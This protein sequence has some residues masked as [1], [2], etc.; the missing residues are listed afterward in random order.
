MRAL[1]LL[2]LFLA[3]AADASV[4]CTTTDL[5]GMA[6][7][8]NVQ[9]GPYELECT[10]VHVPSATAFVVRDPSGTLTLTLG[11]GQVLP[12]AGD[13]IRVRGNAGTTDRGDVRAYAD[14]IVRLGRTAVPEPP[15]A[16][17]GK[18]LDGRFD[19]RVVR[20]QGL[21]IDIIQDEI[22]S[23]FYYLL[24]YADG[25]KL[26]LSVSA[27]G[28]T[29]EDFSRYAYA[30]VEAV[31][32]CSSNLG[33]PRRYLGP[34]LTVRPDALRIL[35]PARADPFDALADD[36]RR[37]RLDGTVAAV[38]HGDRF[39][40][41]TDDGQSALVIVANGRAL[42]AVGRHV[43][44][45][46]VVRT[47][48]FTLCLTSAIWRD[49]PGD[50]PPEDPPKAV[51]A[52]ELL[53]AV[54]SQMKFNA[55]LH[56]R[57]I[58]FEGRV[59]RL[60]V[61]DVEDPSVF[62]ECGPLVIPVNASACPSALEGLDVGCR[63]RATGMAIIE[64][65]E[66]RSDFHFPHATGMSV[67][68]RRP[69]DLELVAR[70]PWWTAGRL[71]AVIGS[72]VLLLIGI[73]IWNRILNR[74]VERRGR[75]LM[76][77]EIAHAEADLK[78]E[79]RTR[80]A[81]ELHDTLAQNLTGVSLQID[82]AEMASAKDPPSARPYLARARMKMQNCRE[83]L[84]DCL[85]DLRSRAIDEKELA[86]AIRRTLAPHLG[87]ATAEIACDV[88]CSDLSDNA[89]H[90][91]LCIVRELVVN[92]IRHGGATAVSVSCALRGGRLSLAVRDDGRGFDPASR[93]GPS[94]GHFGLQGVGER[95]RRLGGTWR[96]DSAPGSGCTVSAEGL[97]ANEEVS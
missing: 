72:L 83:T 85:W 47:D 76:R 55:T 38:W 63:V 70:A 32:Y 44:A 5:S 25:R 54:R 74:L 65:D 30:R 62:L 37:Q 20:T 8:R 68:L 43:R 89:V 50:A 6:G 52:R 95:I 84:R 73:V 4:R 59:S 97:K 22:D 19:R 46:G 77:E 1:A 56:C 66:L 71:T 69:S 11:R 14:E 26:A 23:N 18:I 58:R 42:P 78:L 75:A 39:L 3:A 10:V 40:I 15:V 49:E 35:E 24:L 34:H 80:L 94:D 51:D 93:P 57:I 16:T 12:S 88:R 96:I 53:T 7:R 21:V 92:A 27:P 67:I 90:A 33:F 9:K 28:T 64:T 29:P 91:V 60:G 2:L 36:D 45:V 17:V 79:E 61:R 87:D 86:D 82:A 81:V 31:G 41:R 48:L 13:V